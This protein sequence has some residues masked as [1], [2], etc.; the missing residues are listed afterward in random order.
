MTFVRWRG[1][2]TEL[3]T[4]VY[5]KGRSRHVRL[6]CLSPAHTARPEDRANVAS[7]FPDVRV[8]WDAVDLTLAIGP[9]AAQADR[10]AHGWPN[11]RLEWLHLQ[12]RM[13]YWA[14]LTERVRPAEAQPLRAAATVL[15]QW[16]EGCPSFP[17][18][19]PLPGWDPEPTLSDPGP[20]LG[21][22]GPAQGRAAQRQPPQ[23]DTRKP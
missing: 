5:K 20:F 15:A 7:R 17:D 19:E 4:M 16:R 23:A 12:R 8:D 21:T 9:R 22:P 10:A 14:D 18:P 1:N 2:S 11:D 6:A 13:H 3:L